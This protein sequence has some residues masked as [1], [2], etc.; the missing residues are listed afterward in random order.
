[1]VVGG[2]VQEEEATRCRGRRHTPGSLSGPLGSRKCCDAEDVHDDTIGKWKA[3][4]IQIPK[5]GNQHKKL[6]CAIFNLFYD[7]SDSDI[8]TAR[9][10]YVPTES[11]KRARTRSWIYDEAHIQIC[12]RK[13]ENIL[14]VWRVRKDG[15]YGKDP[16]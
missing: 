3:A 8:E 12:V 7:Q 10:V 6:D 14:A 16:G 15:R 9:A 1:M 4:Q 11:A 5:N 2:A 13:P